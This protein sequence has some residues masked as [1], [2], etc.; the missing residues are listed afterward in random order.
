MQDGMLF[1]IVLISCADVKATYTFITLHV[2][3]F[4]FVVTIACGVVLSNS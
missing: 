4:V 1:H 2:M 3:N